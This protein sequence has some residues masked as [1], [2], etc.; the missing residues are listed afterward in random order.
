MK[1]VTF[2]IAAILCMPLVNGQT[3][4][5]DAPVTGA[6]AVDHLTFLG[7]NGV[8]GAHLMDAH[9]VGDRAYILVGAYNGLE[10]YD[11]SDPTA[12]VR[13]NATGPS[14]WG[15]KHYGDRLYAFCRKYGFSI[16][17]ISGSTPSY[18]GKYD[19]ADPNTLFENGVLLGDTLYVAAH[20]MGIMAFDV[21]NE[22]SPT[23]LR[24]IDLDEND[25]WDVEAVGS[26]LV[27]A[28]GHFGL[29][30]VQLTT[31]PVEAAVL[32]LPG[33]SNH[34]VLDGD[35]GFLSLA[36][37]G[38][39]TVDLSAPL[40]PEVMDRAPSGGNAFGSGIVNHKVAVASWNVLE[41]FDISDPYQIER[42]G[43]EN[44]KTWAQGACIKAYGNDELV[45]VADWRGMSCYK[46]GADP[47]PDIDVQPRDLDFGAVS[48][49]SYKTMLVR[50]TGSTA[51]NVNVG[52]I[53]S[54]IEVTPKVFTVGPG[55]YD[56]VQVRAYGGGSLSNDIRFYS[57]DPDEANVQQYVYK[58]NAS[59]PQ[60]GS[61]APNFNMQDVDGYWHSLGD[62][63]GR[64]IYL[65]FGGLW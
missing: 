60:V 7:H 54:G 29:S 6:P 15:A 38:V 31:P 9:V 42:C 36:G 55:Q 33:L 61:P 64:V 35:V 20:Q 12:P 56:R 45:V 3:M 41:V 50:N 13:I 2:L 4:K 44:T 43:F 49:S 63:H 10:T 21:S 34:I 40:A 23:Y 48:G 25:C 5:P 26:D 51:L 39:A 37:E 18:L 16:Y 53:P 30:V 22:T 57:N 24:T 14:A 19:P 1:A 28:N 65:E 47:G 62:Y 17:D 32:P 46:T 52:S 11:I 58:N 27:V 59:F 8:N